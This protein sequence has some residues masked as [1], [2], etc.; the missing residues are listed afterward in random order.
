V[1]SEYVIL[2]YFC[3][4][5]LGQKGGQKSR[6]E[7]FL[8][9]GEFLKFHPSTQSFYSYW[10]A[11]KTLKYI[12]DGGIPASGNRRLVLESSFN[13]SST[14][15]RGRLKVFYVILQFN[16]NAKNSKITWKGLRLFL[17]C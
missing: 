2:R 8:D 1:N 4:K 9:H 17:G 6:L 11:V 7:S 15:G 5:F 16:R 10:I 14:W 3:P 12:Q 13:L